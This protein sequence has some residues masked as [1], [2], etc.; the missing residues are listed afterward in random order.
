MNQL[1]KLPY[2]LVLDYFSILKVLCTDT[3]VMQVLYQCPLWIIHRCLQLDSLE[4][5]SGE[6]K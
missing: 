4:V 6:E 5:H 3:L 2:Y 1:K